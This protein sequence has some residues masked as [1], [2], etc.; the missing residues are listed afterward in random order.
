MSDPPPRPEP[1]PE[2]L[3]WSP[4]FAWNRMSCRFVAILDSAPEGDV[5][6]R[7]LIYSSQNPVYNHLG[8]LR[9]FELDRSPG[10]IQFVR[11]VDVF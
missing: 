1:F 6:G 7:L 9:T 5:V 11:T 3:E 2:Q 10:R 8:R 4:L